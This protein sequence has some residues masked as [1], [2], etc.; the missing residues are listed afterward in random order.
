MTFAQNLNEEEKRGVAEQLS[1]EELALFDIL[2]RPAIEL[3]DQETTQVKK[4]ARDLLVALKRGKLVLD[5]RKFQGS[6]AAVKVNIEDVLDEGLPESFT[7][8]MF[9]QKAEAVYQ[10]VFDAY[11]GGNKG[12]YAQPAR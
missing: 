4:A 7:A 9:Q 6:R 12:V 5:W 10:H 8:E 1:E 11:Y 2:T 3:T